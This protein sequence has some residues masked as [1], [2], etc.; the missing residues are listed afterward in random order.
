MEIDIVTL[1]PEFAD[2]FFSHSIISRARQAG[3]LTL[4]TVNPRDFTDN[5]FRHVDDTPYG[6]GN[7]MLLQAEPIFKAVESV[8]PQKR[9]DARVILLSPTGAPFTQKK[10]S[11]L[12]RYEHLVLVCGHYEGI[13]ARVED[14]LVDE[15]I[16]IG[17]YVLTGGELPAFIVADAVAR[18]LPGVLGTHASAFDESF[19]EGTLEYPQYTKPA[20]F[21]GYKVPE[22]LLSG[23][24]A[25]IARWRRKQSLLRTRERRPDL[26][27]KLV[28]SDT[29]RKLLAEEDT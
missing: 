9:P 6:G 26:W 25:N 5:K 21:R 2:A 13:D 14:Y 19:I 4:G 15:S 27:R 29:D 3:Y 7:G 10:A 12:T 22:I 20:E 8:L 23:H 1:F 24:H 16:S 11:E 17:D 18:L 28:L